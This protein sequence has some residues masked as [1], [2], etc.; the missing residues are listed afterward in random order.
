M[1]ITR[2]EYITVAELNEVLFTSFPDD[3]DTKKLIIEASELISYHTLK[4]SDVLFNETNPNVSR[5]DNLKIATAYQV[6]YFNNFVD[7]DS[8][9]EENGES[10]G[11][12]RYSNSV[13]GG[14]SGNG[15]IKEWKKIAPKTNRYLQLADLLYKGAD[16]GIS[17]SAN[18]ID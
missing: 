6:E 10:F 16:R 9:Y 11:L 17:R 18:I 1:A 2:K 4:L 3:N 8:E 12:G 13:S 15:G 5:L 7:V 14:G